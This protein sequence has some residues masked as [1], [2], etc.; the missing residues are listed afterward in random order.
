VRAGAP[1]EALTT[2]RRAFMR[3]V[4]QRHEIIVAL[5]DAP[6]AAVDP[7]ALRASF[8]A[9]YHQQFGRTIP[10]LEI[11]VLSWSVIVET[12]GAEARAAVP[13]RDV[14]VEERGDGARRVRQLLDPGS[15]K[16]I[17][18]RIVT[19][20]ALAPGAVLDGPA[21]VV[22]NDTSTVVPQGFR[23]TVNSHAY[24]VLARDKR[25]SA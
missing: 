13:V 9:S 17:D 4:G 22:E 20:S 25:L 3:Y 18:A 5:P 11:E 8:E 12:A 16:R 23:L 1:N 24:L 14:P 7:A 10:K 21:I 6:L 2:R 15:G 19:R